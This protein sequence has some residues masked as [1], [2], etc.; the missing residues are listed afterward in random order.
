MGQMTLLIFLE[1][2]M[3]NFPGLDKERFRR[4]NEAEH[5]FC[6]GKKIPLQIMFALSVHFCE[7]ALPSQ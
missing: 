2:R 6:I 7:A 5:P 1:G 4:E 3:L